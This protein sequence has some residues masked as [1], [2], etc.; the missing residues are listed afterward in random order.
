ML[1]AIEAVLNHFSAEGFNEAI[2][3][4]P[5]RG[6]L[7]LLVDLLDFPRQALFHKLAGNAEFPVS[8]VFTGD[9]VSHLCKPFLL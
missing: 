9:V 6:R 7:N 3:C 8:D 1:T 2:I 4:M 5:H